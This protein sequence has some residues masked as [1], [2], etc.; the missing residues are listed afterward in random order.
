MAR[1]I[2][3]ASWR[4]IED[5]I[6]AGIPVPCGFLHRGPVTAPSGGGHWLTVVG[7]DRDNLIVHDPFGMADLISGATL[8]GV[9][10]FASYSRR[11]FGPRWMVVGANTGWAV[12]AER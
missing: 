3:T 5:Q 6:A 7:H 4:T 9:A 2:K 1:F 10:R 12:I 11:N 8:G